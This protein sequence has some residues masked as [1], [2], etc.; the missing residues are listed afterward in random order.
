MKDVKRVEQCWENRCL[1][2]LRGMLRSIHGSE[3]GMEGRNLPGTQEH[4]GADEESSRDELR[5]YEVR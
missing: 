3:M 4:T 2:I 1:Q 5:D